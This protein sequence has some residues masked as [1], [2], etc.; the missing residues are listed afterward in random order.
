CKPLIQLVEDIGI[1]RLQP[2]G[3][4]QFA[5][6]ERLELEHTFA[7]QRGM[8]LDHYSAE[9]LNG[10]S[11]LTVVIRWNCAGIEETSRIVEFDL[12]A[13]KRRRICIRKL[14]QLLQSVSD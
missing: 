11:N 3:D 4:F 12:R 13:R 7:D 8:T 5:I 14:R 1:R 10:F 6:K 9:R 2:D